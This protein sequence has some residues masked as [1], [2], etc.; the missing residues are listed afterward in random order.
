M[1]ADFIFEK[2]CTLWIQI[3]IELT[4]FLIIRLLII[5]DKL[6]E[7]EILEETYALSVQNMSS[8]INLVKTRNMCTIE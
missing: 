7:N 5:F 3:K 6:K 8:N 2:K 1:L 4:T